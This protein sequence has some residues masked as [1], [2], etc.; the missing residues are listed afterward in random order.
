[1][2][3][4][5]KYFFIKYALLSWVSKFKTFFSERGLKPITPFLVSQ[6]N[7]AEFDVNSSYDISSIIKFLSKKEIG[8]LFL[9]LNFISYK[10]HSS[11]IKFLL[12]FFEISFELI[13]VLSDPIS[14]GISYSL[15]FINIEEDK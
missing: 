11:I 14:I 12:L 2:S 5:E 6:V 10:G 13:Q 7:S 15:S 3:Y 1:M 4:I 9:L 8:I